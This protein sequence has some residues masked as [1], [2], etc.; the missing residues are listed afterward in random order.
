M[1]P[2]KVIPDQETLA[3]SHNEVYQGPFAPLP[4]H[5]LEGAELSAAMEHNRRMGAEFRDRLYSR[6]E[7]YAG[8]DSL[9]EIEAGGRAKDNHPPVG[10]SYAVATRHIAETLDDLGLSFGQCQ[11]N[12]ATDALLDTNDTESILTRFMRAFALRFKE[13]DSRFEEV[14]TCGIDPKLVAPFDGALDR[15]YLN[16]I[17][18]G[19]GVDN[20][21]NANDSNAGVQRE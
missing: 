8:H 16:K 3:S 10:L 6:P 20:F 1:P 17:L 13:E 21:L 14:E 7:P 18:V 5:K 9:E 19:N 4:F 12:D 11:D 15:A 2:G